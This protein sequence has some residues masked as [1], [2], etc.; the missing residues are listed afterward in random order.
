MMLGLAV[1]RAELRD[2]ASARILLV[3]LAPY[4]DRYAVLGSGTMFFGAVAAQLGRLAS[5]TGDWEAA[6]IECSTTPR[7]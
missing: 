4:A 1:A 2:A 6:E 7:P 5:I 3:H